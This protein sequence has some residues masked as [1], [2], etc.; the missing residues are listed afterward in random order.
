M[1]TLLRYPHEVRDAQEYFDEIQDVKATRDMLDLARHIVEQKSAASSPTSSRISTKPLLSIS[2]IRN[3]PASRSLRR[4]GPAARMSS[5]YGGAAPERRRR[6]GPGQGR[7]Q[8][9]PEEAGQEAAQGGGRQNEMLMPITG[10][11]PAKEAAAKKPPS[12]NGG[13]PDA[14]VGEPHGCERSLGN[15][16]RPGWS[17]SRTASS[18]RPERAGDRRTRLRRMSRCA[19]PTGWARWQS[20]RRC[21]RCS[22]RCSWEFGSRDAARKPRACASWPGVLRPRDSGALEGGAGGLGCRQQP[23]HQGFAKEG[24]DPNVVAATMPRPGVRGAFCTLSGLFRSSDD[25]PDGLR[26]R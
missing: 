6:G 25:I 19:G 9:G 17:T 12:H 16:G 4:S 21:S 10:K 24:D 23:P 26:G 15:D 14:G 2:S 1:G 11:A 5:I 8:G 18:R 20:R 22:P 13:P 3:A 7:G